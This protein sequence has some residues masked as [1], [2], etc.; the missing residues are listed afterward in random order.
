MVGQT[1]KV[2]Y[3][4]TAIDTEKDTGNPESVFDGGTCQGQ[5]CGAQWCTPI[6]IPALRSLRKTKNYSQLLSSG[7]SICL[8]EERKEW[9]GEA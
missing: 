2:I 3:S 8:R 7:H 9:G 6:I 5:K 4:S 1:F